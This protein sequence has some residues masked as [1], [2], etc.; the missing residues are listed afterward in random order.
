MQNNP[1]VV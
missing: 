1:V